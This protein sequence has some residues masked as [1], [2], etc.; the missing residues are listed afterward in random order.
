MQNI[1]YLV[2][3]GVGLVVVSGLILKKKNRRQQICENQLSELASRLQNLENKVAQNGN[4]VAQN[5]REILNL[6]KIVQEQEE[7]IMTCLNYLSKMTDFTTEASLHTHIVASDRFRK[8]FKKIM[9]AQ[10][11]RN[12]ITTDYVSD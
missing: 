9:D 8:H 1:I 3:G 10:A 2:V 7:L 12:K 4:K 5:G 11:S 6:Q